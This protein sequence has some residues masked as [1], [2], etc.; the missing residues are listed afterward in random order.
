MKIFATIKSRDRKMTFFLTNGIFK[1]LFTRKSL[2]ATSSSSG[3]VGVSMVNEIRIRNDVK[4]LVLV[5]EILRIPIESSNQFFYY[6]LVLYDGTDTLCALIDR[7]YNSSVVENTA[8]YKRLLDEQKKINPSITAV[9]VKLIQPGT[10]L[11]FDT[12]TFKRW[13]CKT[14]MDV[15]EILFIRDFQLVGMDEQFRNQVWKNYLF[16][17]ENCS[18]FENIDDEDDEN[19]DHYSDQEM[20]CCFK[21]AETLSPENAL[22][23][24][25]LHHHQS[26]SPT[27]SVLAVILNILCILTK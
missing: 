8:E 25:K 2:L 20:D 12:Y 21:C 27:S 17:K 9:D 10:V 14:H 5:K 18:V 19:G 15:D 6:A 23:K 26:N 16:F 1:K 4:P 11:T 7:S 24:Q 3:S 22:K 13:H